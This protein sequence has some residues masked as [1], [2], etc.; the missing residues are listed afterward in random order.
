MGSLFIGQ[1]WGTYCN[2]KAVPGLVFWVKADAI[3][4]LNDGDPVPTW[5]DLSGHGYDATA[6]GTDRP[7]YKVNMLNGLPVIGFSNNKMVTSTFALSQPSTVFLV[8]NSN[9]VSGNPEFVDA[10][11]G[12]RI[13]YELTAT[14]AWGL[15]GGDFLYSAVAYS[16]SYVVIGGIFSG[17]NSLISV[18]GTTATGSG[19]TLTS[20]GM[21]IGGY[22]GGSSYLSGDIGEIVAYSSALSTANRQ[23]IEGYLAW[24]WGLQANLAAGHPWKVMSP[25]G[26]R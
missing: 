3:K 13:L 26:P 14:T 24:R 22:P 20:S 21:A 6:S 12:R 10:A 16:S 2:P 5:A 9:T 23:G 18:N 25:C 4:G 11:Q 1:D 7:A 19:G 8:G 17:L 15:Y